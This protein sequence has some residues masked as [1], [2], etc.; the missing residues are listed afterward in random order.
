[1]EIT[2]TNESTNVE[3]KVKIG[4]VDYT[5]NYA[6]KSGIITSLNGSASIE[7]SNKGTFNMYSN[8]G[9]DSAININTGFN[10]SSNVDLATKLT[11]VTD[12]TAIVTELGI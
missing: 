4:S 5:F 3:A 2:K 12:V 8:V 9:I 6:I 11:V 10:F 1:M 7:G